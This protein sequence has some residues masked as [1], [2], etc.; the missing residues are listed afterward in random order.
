M[1]RKA[2]KKMNTSLPLNTCMQSLHA[3]A[4]S[5]SERLSRGEPVALDLGEVA[6]RGEIGLAPQGEE[7]EQ[8]AG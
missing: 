5:A 8:E 6:G 2:G 1:G 3:E 7:D 4:S